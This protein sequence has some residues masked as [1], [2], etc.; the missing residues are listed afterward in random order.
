MDRG[1]AV[2]IASAAI[3]LA[4]GSVALYASAT[5]PLAVDGAWF[6]AGDRAATPGTDGRPRFSLLFAPNEAGLRFGLSLRNGTLLPETVR[7]APEPPPGVGLDYLTGLRVC[8]AGT[9]D[10][11]FSAASTLGVKA[12]EIP[13]RSERWVVF[14]GR[15][16]GCDI[17]SEGGPYW[18][19][20]RD[21]VLVTTSLLGVDQDVDLELPFEQMISVPPPGVC[22]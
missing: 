4:L 5:Q 14:E 21:S 17:V 11:C 16:A 8:T 15:F 20:T 7:L 6:A 12:V 3:A 19:A 18:V 1:R 9:P 13:A 10:G 2:G 22:P